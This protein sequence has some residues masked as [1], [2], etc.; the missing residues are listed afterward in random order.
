[1]TGRIRYAFE[2]ARIPALVGQN[3][4]NCPGI[5]FT[6][7]QDRGKTASGL[8]RADQARHFKVG[9][10]AGAQAASFSIELASKA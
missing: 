6:F 10:Q 7:V 5:A 1:M 9:G 2:K 3:Y 8:R 4:N